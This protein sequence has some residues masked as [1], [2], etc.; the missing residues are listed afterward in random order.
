MLVNVTV[1][2]LYLREINTVLILE[3]VVLASGPVWMRL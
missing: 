1:R 3:E 2:P